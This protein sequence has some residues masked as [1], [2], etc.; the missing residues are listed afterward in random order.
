MPGLLGYFRHGAPDRAEVER[1][2]DRMAAAV[3][4]RHRS[5]AARWGD[6]RFGV[7]QYRFERP[8]TAEAA[9]A[10][11]PGADEPAAPL[12]F[13]DGFLLNAA[14]VTADLRAN[15]WG[16]HPVAGEAA[17]VRAAYQRYGAAVAG[18]L[19]GSFNVCV[20][21]PQASRLEL[22]N[23]RHGA[24]H[25]FCRSTPRYFAFAYEAKAL[26]AL[27]DIRPAVD[28]LAVFDMFNFGYLGGTRTLFAGIELLD[29]ATVAT[30]RPDR[31][32]RR[33]YWDYCYQNTGPGPTEEDLV[34][35]GAALLRQAVGR[36]AARFRH[37]GVPLSGGL[38]SRTIL[39]FAAE[40][41]QSLPVFHCSWYDLEARLARQLCQAAGGCWHEYDPSAFD[42][43]EATAEGADLSDGN[44]HAH[45]FWFLPVVRQVQQEG[46]AELLLDGY[47]MDV[48]LGDTFL[49]L[50]HRSHYTAEQCRGLVN[51]I[52]RRGRP[53]FVH[54][55]FTARF[56]GA[57]EDANRHSID[58]CLATIDEEHISNIIQRFSLA[59]RS[60]RYSVALPNVHRQ[61]VEYG[62]PGLDYEVTDFYLRL[63][64]AVKDGAR[65]YR[66]LICQAL[67]ASAAVPWVKTGKPLS[68]D[69]G[70]I[71]R[72]LGRL[73]ARQLA[74]MLL[75]RATGGRVDCSYRGDL[76]RRF[77]R[78]PAYRSWLTGLLRDPRTS[79]RG[80]IERA[81]VERLIG[82]V[83][84]GW[85]VLS[86]V[87]SLVTVELWQRRFV[88]A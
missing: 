87:Q 28:E 7:V 62:Y 76:N 45:Q 69:K 6:A 54:A 4:P 37:L 19:H 36:Y 9:A 49:V 2:L 31:V 35:E 75:L 25:L 74:S 83:D 64:P 30:V 11:D 52:W 8:D 26:V 84:R 72:R 53:G 48:F 61:F 66:R 21:D 70:W 67:P 88:D 60:N 32:E 85:P 20:Y 71:S 38:D 77:R 79:S 5:H 50:P 43:A 24:R 39:G 12:T 23:C 80:Y 68:A 1:Q 56:A 44:V 86:L 65:F 57:Y 46:W 16:G 73:P 63:P 34:T 17:L 42:L 3:R 15:G 29:H 81:G 22:F 58:A 18:R 33:R 41:R 59:N 27:D 82:F 10:A 55:A 14:E 78:D 40:Q 13:M 47:L 51:A